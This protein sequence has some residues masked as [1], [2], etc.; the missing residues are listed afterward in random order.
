MKKVFLLVEDHI[1]AAKYDNLLK[2][3][4]FD[5]ESSSTVWTMLEKIMGLKPDVVLLW[6]RPFG[7]N[8]LFELAI[9][10]REQAFHKGKLVVVS[11]GITL[12]PRELMKAKVDGLIEYPVEN[13]KLLSI[14]A[15][16]VGL[17]PELLL[18]KYNKAQWKD[19]DYSQVRVPI[20]TGTPARKDYSKMQFAEV[21]DPAKTTFSDKSKL[22]A[23]WNEVESS[24]DEGQI[25]KINEQKKEFVTALFKASKA[26]KQD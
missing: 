2:K 18:E 3:V 6:V 12:E 5:V 17:K 15:T 11:E 9:K 14:L 24:T 16:L 8:N 1:A 26:K 23:L 7:K 21:I 13:E 20:K 4:G 25:D 19:V 22:K 10:A